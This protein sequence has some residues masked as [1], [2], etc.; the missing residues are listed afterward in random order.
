MS[1]QSRWSGLLALV[2][3]SGRGRRVSARQAPRPRSPLSL[4][5]LEDRL[6]PS[7]TVSSTNFQPALPPVPSLTTTTV[8]PTQ[9]NLSWTQSAGVGS[10]EVEE[11]VS[12]QWKVIAYLGRGATADAVTGLTPDTTY[13]FRVGAS[14][15]IGTQFSADRSATTS[16]TPFPAH[17]FAPYVDETT[18]SVYPIASVAQN[19]G[20]KYFSLAFIEADSH[21]QPSWGGN[22][23]DEL[24]SAFDSALRAQ[25]TAVRQQGGN[26][27]VSFGGARG[28]DLAQVIT[29][30]SAL[31]TA[32]ASI[33]NAYHLTRID[34]D[35]EGAALKDTASI[36]RRSQ[37][38]AAVQQQMAK[39]GQQL[40]VTFTLPVNPT[41]LE[42]NALY[43][44]QSARDH[45]L[46][47]TAVNVM[48]MDYGNAT[49]P[50]PKGQMGTLAIEA[51]TN[52]FNQLQGLYGSSK[53]AAE[54]WQMIAITSRIGVNNV[55]D[56]V[57]DQAAARQ[58]L[59]FAQAKGLNE[60]SFWALNRDQSG[61][62]SPTSSGISQ[63]PFEFSKIMEI[64]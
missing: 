8:S 4:E 17:L 3:G 41:G 28:K 36:D 23:D 30:L 19:E 12:G 54:L 51:A 35:V 14:N 63:T 29:K 42:A 55:S 26:V 21:N 46:N 15:R 45:G 40:Q 22:S 53:T 33:I 9:I 58:V 10:Y 7:T 44:L 32:Y 61:P 59:A 27:I 47:I 38:L 60:L 64:F 6:V 13:S 57:F 31:E 48:A 39:V 11:Q 56:E 24:G 49:V 52:T 34:M 1:L 5:M 50:N 43:V 20:V 16:I 25:I 37:A 18:D 2:C 62:N